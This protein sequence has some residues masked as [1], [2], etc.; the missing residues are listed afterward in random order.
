MDGSFEKPSPALAA[1]IALP[2]GA[3]AGQALQAIAQACAEHIR[4]N[5][6]ALIQSEA[7][8]ALHQI[9]VSLRRWRAAVDALGA[10]LDP[11]VR[12]AAVAELKWLAGELDDARDLDVLSE[13]LGAARAAAGLPDG[14]LE[15]LRGALTHA[16]ATARERA[17][18]ALQSDRTKRLLWDGP[19]SAAAPSGD[20]GELLARDLVRDSLQRQRA[21][22]RK[23][24]RRLG[25]M[26]PE[27]RHRLRIRTKKARY[28][29]E[30]FGGLF[31]HPGRQDAF[32]G[33]LKDLQAA[34]GEL[35]DIHVAGGLMRRLAEKAGTWDAGLAAGV[36]AGQG[37]DREASLLRKAARAYGRFAKVRRFW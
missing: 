11:A 27:A 37:A 20:E 10:A 32:S 12:D 22:L 5:E 4:A 24:G 15:G 7:P 26:A 19:R 25:A 23:R 6:A 16:R 9:R 3:T 35:N 21:A 8:E 1:P 29:A 17:A 13:R 30:L 28:A 33:V 14:G 2:E 34:L 18:E 36:L 31:G